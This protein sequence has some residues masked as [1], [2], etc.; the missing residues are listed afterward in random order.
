MFNLVVI[1]SQHL[2]HLMLV[3]ALLLILALANDLAW[4]AVANLA[5][6]CKVWRM[7]CRCHL[8][9]IAIFL[10]TKIIRQ[11]GTILRRYILSTLILTNSASVSRGFPKSSGTSIVSKHLQIPVRLRFH[12][13]GGTAPPH[14]ALE[15]VRGEKER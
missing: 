13:L 2:N 4:L 1:F 15:T 5:R 9:S 14:S 7:A 6:R 3:P 10:F 12:R 8:D 11:K